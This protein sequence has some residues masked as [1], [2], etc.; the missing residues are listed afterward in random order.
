LIDSVLVAVQ[1]KGATIAAKP[2]VFDRIHDEIGG[3]GMKRMGICHGHTL[4]LNVN[5]LEKK[6]S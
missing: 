6:N 2:L 4:A 3:Q 5:R 1:R